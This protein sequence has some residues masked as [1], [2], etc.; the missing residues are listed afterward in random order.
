M[1]ARLA[2]GGVGADGHV[3]QLHLPFARLYERLKRVR[4]GVVDLEAQG[5]IAR[6]GSEAADRVRDVSFRDLAHNRTAEVLHQALAFSEM[7]VSQRLTVANDHVGLVGKNGGYQFADLTAG[8]LVIGVGIDDDVR[9]KR[10]RELHTADEGL[11]KTTVAAVPQDV[12]RAMLQRHLGGAVRGAIVD[13]QHDHF[14]DSRDLP[15]DL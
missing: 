3:H 12:V 13:H 2:H 8:V 4:V 1:Q 10:Q 7:L 5:G 11:R 6:E 9:A 15:W 14:V